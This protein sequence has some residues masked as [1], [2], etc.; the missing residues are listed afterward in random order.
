MII[1]VAPTALPLGFEIS[2]NST[3]VRFSPLII[4]MSVGSVLKPQK[5]SSNQETNR[6]RLQASVRKYRINI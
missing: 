1:S 5:H 2:Y 6:A 3:P 4:L